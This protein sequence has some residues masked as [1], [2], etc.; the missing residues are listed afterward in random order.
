ML[1]I[2]NL[3]RH[4]SLMQWFTLV[5]ATAV[6]PLTSPPPP[7][8]PTGHGGRCP[9]MSTEPAQ[10]YAPA[11]ASVCPRPS[12]LRKWQD[13][14][15]GLFLHWGAY[16][17]IGVD[18][19]WSLNWKTA[20]TFGN[21][22]LCAPKPCSECTQEDMVKYRAMYWGL[23]KT[24]NPTKFN[25]TAWAAAASAAGMEYFVMTTKHHDGFAMYNTSQR[26]APGQP[27]Y[28][29]TGADCPTQRDLFGEVTAAMRKEGLAVGAYYSKADWHS[30]SF[31]DPS[32]GFAADRNA[33]YNTG[34]NASKW[35]QFVDFDKAQF[36]EIERMYK[37]DL[38]WLDAGWVGSGTQFL[39][40]ATWAKE[41][42]KD[43][44][45]QLWVR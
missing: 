4:I 29:V 23:S 39:P 11:T 13:Y 32:L 34:S 40:L 18:A 17:Q 16:S 14:K 28:G 33:N 42:R 22:T 3:N 5:L 27:V 41:H 37:P 6:S 9:F 8:T 45:N 44:P 31:W 24:F 35:Q 25:A 36:E 43:N 12:A 2:K 30:N 7:P 15:F 1:T 19:S 26:G 38:F 21:P 20:C 10:A